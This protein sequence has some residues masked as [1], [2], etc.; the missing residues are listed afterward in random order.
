M[1]VEFNTVIT[2][3][4]SDIQSGKIETIHWRVEAVDGEYSSSIYGTCTDSANT[5]PGYDLV[6]EQ[7]CIDLV[8]DVVNI[9]QLRGQLTSE[10]QRTKVPVKRKDLPWQARAGE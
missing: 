6:T 9:N 2:Q 1:P 10:I 4:D 3:V 8:E 7:E 5:L